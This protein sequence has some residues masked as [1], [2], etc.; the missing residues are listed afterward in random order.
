MAPFLSLKYAG[1]F[2]I[3]LNRDPAMLQHHNHQT[4]Q[5]TRRK[6]GANLSWHE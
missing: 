4:N 6:N 3:N 1:T 5:W 2:S